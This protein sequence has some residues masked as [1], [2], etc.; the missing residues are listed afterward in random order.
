MVGEMLMHAPNFK[1]QKRLNQDVILS[2]AVGERD[3]RKRRLLR[4]HRRSVNAAFLGFQEMLEIAEIL[5]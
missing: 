1:P 3:A 5:I 4:H 2:L